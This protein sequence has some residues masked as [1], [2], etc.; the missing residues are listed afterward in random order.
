MSHSCFETYQ[1]LSMTKCKKLE[2]F[3]LTWTGPADFSRTTLFTCYSSYTIFFP[4]ELHFPPERIPFHAPVF[5][6]QYARC[7][8]LSP[9]SLKV[10]SSFKTQVKGPISS[11]PFV[12]TLSPFTHLHVTVFLVFL[13]VT[14]QLDRHFCAAGA[15]CAHAVL[16]LHRAS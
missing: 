8:S 13:C 15:V 12:P 3:S 9:P 7:P 10:H 5:A 6:L 2:F 1:C 11:Q 4:I 14:L 16:G